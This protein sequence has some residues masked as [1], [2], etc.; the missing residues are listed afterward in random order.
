MRQRP[1]NFVLNNTSPLAR[2]LVFAGLAGGNCRGSKAYY[3]S[4]SRKNHGQ[5]TNMDPA[6]DWV[7]VPEL[8]R[9]GLDFDGS[10]DY[11][12]CNTSFFNTTDFTQLSFGG[13]WSVRDDDA[14]YSMGFGN[15]SSNGA[16]W[17]Y[18][19]VADTWSFD[20]AG[21]ELV[22]NSTFAANADL[23]HFMGVFTTGSMLLYIDGVLDNSRGGPSSTSTSIYA[24]KL[25]ATGLPGN[26]L[27]GVIV[28]PV[29]YNR[30]ISLP[31]IQILADRSDPMLSGL[32]KPPKRKYW[33]I[34][35]IR[36]GYR[37]KIGR[38]L[39]QRT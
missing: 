4:S 30:A 16:T 19:Y 17:R 28:D 10:N 5:L 3:D 22:S 21:T 13:W 35:H 24:L 20:V 18:R 23:H 37:Y 9:W 33:G 36:P 26:Y 34:P 39:L 25:G 29:I 27:N 14:Q 32:V 8:G 7:W 12:S 38:L 15:T 31:E 1:E 2:G 11:V 6:T